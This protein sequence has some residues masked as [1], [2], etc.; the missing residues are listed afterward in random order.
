MTLIRPRRIT[1]QRTRGW[2]KPAAAVIVDRTS[3]WGNPFTVA[4][5]LAASEDQARA[6]CREQYRRWITEAVPGQP[7]VLGSG[8]RTFDRRWVRA[9][10]HELRG[11]VLCCPCPA[12]SPCHADVLGELADLCA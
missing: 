11:R 12:G 6:L 2:R 10:L 1:R 3:R 5:A 8:R 7:D 4:A 9:H